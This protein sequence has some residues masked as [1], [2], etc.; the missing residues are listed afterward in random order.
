MQPLLLGRFGRES[1]KL[2]P[3]ASVCAGNRSGWPC[4]AVRWP[5]AVFFVS[6]RPLVAEFRSEPS[7]LY[8]FGAKSMSQLLLVESLE[9]SE[10]TVRR[11]PKSEIWMILPIFEGRLLVFWAA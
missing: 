2:M 4:E 7:I 9:C 11:L 5:G 3:Y 8:G 1:T 10:S 6:A